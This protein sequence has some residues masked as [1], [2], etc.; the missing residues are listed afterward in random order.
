[1]AYSISPSTCHLRNIQYICVF[2]VVIVAI[3]YT[4]QTTSLDGGNNHSHRRQKPTEYHRT[5]KH[6]PIL[7]IRLTHTAVWCEW[8]STTDW[9]VFWMKQPTDDSEH[10]I[11]IFVC[12]GSM[13]SMR[14][15]SFTNTHMKRCH[16]NS[17]SAS[18]NAHPTCNGEKMEHLI[19]SLYE[20]LYICNL[21]CLL[22]I[23]RASCCMGLSIVCVPLLLLLLYGTVFCNMETR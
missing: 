8:V 1:M 15:F 17:D 20:Y 5:L 18:H 3:L 12:V 14:W 23:I 6:T 13:L 7:T 19:Q 21:V 11:F 9:V 16:R 22:P 2:N 4:K 10:K